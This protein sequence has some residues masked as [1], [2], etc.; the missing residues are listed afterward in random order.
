M[1]EG[2][3]MTKHTSGD[4]EPTPEEYASKMLAGVLAFERDEIMSMSCRDIGDV[5]VKRLKDT[6]IILSYNE[7]AFK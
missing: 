1:L 7:E 2:R 4:K 3:A 5:M 6:G